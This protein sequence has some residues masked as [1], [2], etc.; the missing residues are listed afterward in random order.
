MLFQQSPDYHM[1]QSIT[2]ISPIQHIYQNHIHHMYQSHIHHIHLS[3]PSHIN[4]SHSSHINNSIGTHVSI[5]TT[6]CLLIYSS[7]R[8]ISA[9][10]SNVRFEHSKII[11]SL[12]FFDSMLHTISRFPSIIPSIFLES[13]TLFKLFIPR[14]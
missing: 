12:K 2:C 8:L 7:D 14:S 5:R 4:R 6:T 11:S 9:S 10:S 13:S 3:H 1:Y